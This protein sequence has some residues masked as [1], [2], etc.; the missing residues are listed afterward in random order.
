MTHILGIVEAGF[1]TS[2]SEELLDTM[3]LDEY[4]IEREEA[5]YLLKVTTSSM[6]NAG[7]LE[8]DTLIVER[9]RDP[10]RGDIVIV[11]RG[12]D[13]SMEYFVRSDTPFTVAA[14]VRGVV[15][16]YT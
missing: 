3:S 15:R 6:Q 2:A 9:G 7:I 8:G 4:L 11:E 16:K 10:K 14:V 13:Y 12:G 5:T 1:P